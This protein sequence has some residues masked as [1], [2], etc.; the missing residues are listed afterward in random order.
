MGCTDGECLFFHAAKTRRAVP[1][2]RLVFKM[3]CKDFLTMYGK[4][5]SDRYSAMT[6]HLLK[7]LAEHRRAGDEP[8][9]I[10]TAVLRRECIITSLHEVDVRVAPQRRVRGAK[11][12]RVECSKRHLVRKLVNIL[13]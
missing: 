8:E 9:A 13:A 6:G 7:R 10:L 4:C 2:S 12:G 3:G 11:I 5:L 1:V